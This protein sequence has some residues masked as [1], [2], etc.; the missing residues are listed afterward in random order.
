M[1]KV[2]VRSPCVAHVGG[3]GSRG[4]LAGEALAPSRQECS[5]RAAGSAVSP[6]RSCSSLAAAPSLVLVVIATTRR[7]GSGSSA[8]SGSRVAVLG[9]GR[10]IQQREYAPAIRRNSRPALDQVPVLSGKSAFHNTIRDMTLGSA[11]GDHAFRAH[12]VINYPPDV[13]DDLHD[14]LN[15][16]QMSDTP[17]NRHPQG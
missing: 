16:R 17:H 1:S 15:A 3:W 11:P 4:A 9:Y 6:P 10:S 13:E 14:Q 2:R 5:Q 7:R 12:V 8:R